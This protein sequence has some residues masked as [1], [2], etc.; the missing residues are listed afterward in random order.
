[1]RKL[2]FATLLLS[3]RLFAIDF[4]TI[5]NPCNIPASN[6]KGVVPNTY[7]ISKYE[8]TNTDY[9]AFLN[10]CASTEDRF[11]LFS[12]LMEEHFFGGICRTITANGFVYNIKPGYQN[13][14]VIGVTWMSAIRYCNWLHYNSA[15]IE[16]GKPLSEYIMLT[17]GDSTHGA[18][19]TI[20]VPSQRNKYARYWLPSEDEWLKAA[21]FDGKEWHELLITEGSNC[22]TRKGWAIPYPHIKAVGG[23]PSHYGTYD[24]QGNVAEWIE[25]SRSSDGQWKL[26]LGGSLIRPVSFAAFTE[27]EGDYPD[28]SI[29][30]FGLRICRLSDAK[31]LGDAPK[32]W[33][34]V[35]KDTTEPAAITDNLGNYYVLVADA[36]NRGDIANRFLGRVN[37]CY[38]I[39]KTELSNSS[40]CSFLNAVAV[41]ADP[42]GLYDENMARAAC[43]G[44]IQTKIGNK[45]QYRCK[46][47]WEERPVVYVNYY[48]ICRY[49]NWMHYGCPRTGKCELGTTEGTKVRGAYDTSDFEEVRSGQK[50]A[51]ESFGKRNKGAKFWIPSENEWYK[52]AYYDPQIIGNRKY[53]DYP[54]RSSIPPS[55]NQ[56]NY[57][58]NNHLA[59]GNPYFVAPVDSFDNAP[60]YYG[61]LQQG[62]NVWEWIEDWQYGIIG[63]RGLRGGSWSYTFYGL[64]AINTDPGGLDNSG[65]VFG[66]RLCQQA[67]PNGWQPVSTP[68]TDRIHEYIMLLPKKHLLFVLGCLTLI[69]AIGTIS[70]MMA[71]IRLLIDSLNKKHDT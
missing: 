41:F 68:I 59:L 23:E 34:P 42:Y 31:S 71:I 70:I 67:T 53:H 6:G 18:Y 63:S 28:K 14:P 15:N 55:Q 33:S 9:C 50:R 21:Y 3:S 7:Q 54:T 66:A 22:Y 52:A 49:A 60:S 29:T 27:S 51:Y 8:I 69:S 61:T 10:C 26:A 39:S 58:V 56:A 11:Q 1:M 17:E 30:S 65:Y 35:D 37:Y 24:Q 46:D 45:Y 48:D 32:Y 36:G 47:G 13:I 4:V 16:S 62:G 43:G 44:I 20:S 25:S 19:S 5:G 57:M 40:Y 2:I 64:N 12:P 38:C